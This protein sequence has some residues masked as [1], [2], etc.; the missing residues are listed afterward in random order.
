MAQGGG[1]PFGRVN[2]QAEDG[3]KPRKLPRGS[4]E[5][6]CLSQRVNPPAMNGTKPRKLPRG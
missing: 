5:V 6:G 2:P 3:T 4:S 1:D